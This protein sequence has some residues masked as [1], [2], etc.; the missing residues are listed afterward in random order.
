MDSVVGVKHVLD[1]FY[2]FWGL[3]VNWSKCEIFYS[4][5]SNSVIGAI[6]EATEFSVGQLPIR[7]LGVPLVSKHLSLKDCHPL[8]DKFTARVSTGFFSYAGKLKLIQCVI[9][10]LQN[11]WCRQFLLPKRI[12]KHVNSICS[13]FFWEN[14]SN[15]HVKARI[16]WHSISFPKAEGGLGLKDA[17]S[18][19]KA[20][21]LRNLWIISIQAGSFMGCLV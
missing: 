10:S 6:Q 7:Y 20:C 18:C 16:S 12:V 17:F 4:A 3:Q 5:I 13:K 15:G 2:I 9:S 14:K 1:L 19:N 21:F 11:Y 8:I